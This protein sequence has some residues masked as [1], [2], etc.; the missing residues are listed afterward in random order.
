MLFF[1]EGVATVSAEALAAAQ[2]LLNQVSLDRDRVL[3][4]RNASVAGLRLLDQLPRHPLVT[5]PRVA[6][7]LETTRPTAAKA[8]ALLESLGVLTE[9]SGRKRDRTFSYAGYLELLGSGME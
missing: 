4:S 8:V 1:L 9:V 6:K 2:G 5:I 7:L 3:R